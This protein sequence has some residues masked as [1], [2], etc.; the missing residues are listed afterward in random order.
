MGRPTDDP[1]TFLIR[2]R[3]SEDMHNRIEKYCVDNN[4]SRT[5]IVRMGIEKVLKENKKE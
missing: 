2:A 4:V 3:I 5:D 1:K